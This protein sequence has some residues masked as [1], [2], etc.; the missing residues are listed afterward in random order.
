[1]CDQTEKNFCP[2][3]VPLPFAYSA[4]VNTRTFMIDDRGV[5]TPNRWHI[6]FRSVGGTGLKFLSLQVAP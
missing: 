4:G 6:P 5:V 3:N 1:M 2:V